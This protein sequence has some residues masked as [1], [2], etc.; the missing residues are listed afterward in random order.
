VCPGDQ[1]YLVDQ[2]PAQG[3]EVDQRVALLVDEIDS[4]AVE[5]FDGQRRPLPRM[6]RQQDHRQRPLFHDA[7]NGP[8][9]AHPGHE[10][11]ESDDVGLP[12]VELGQQ[13]LARGRGTHDH[14]ARLLSQ[15]AHHRLAHEGGVVHH[16]DADL[17]HSLVFR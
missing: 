14:D 5:R 15:H 10:E 3:L 2:D 12:G 9:T 6:A 8:E 13:L 17:L 1:E 11:I 16:R 7:I 4:A